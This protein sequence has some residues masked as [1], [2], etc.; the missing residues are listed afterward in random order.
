MCVCVGSGVCVGGVILESLT[1]SVCLS[2]LQKFVCFVGFSVLRYHYN[3][4]GTRQGKVL[5]MTY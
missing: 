5:N 1:V 4:L 3:I 2:C